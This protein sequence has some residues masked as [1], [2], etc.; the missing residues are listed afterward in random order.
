MNRNSS[1]YFIALCLAGIVAGFDASIVN[2]AFPVIKKAL[3]ANITQMQ[4]M[5]TCFS[6]LFSACTVPFGMLSDL[7][8][9]RE[10]L[11]ITLIVLTL[12]SLGAGLAQTPWFLMV[13]RGLQ[14]ACV[15]MFFPCAVGT[16]QNIFPEAI[17]VRTVSIFFALFGVGVGIGPLLGAVLMHWLS[18]RWVFFINIPFALISLFITYIWGIE[19]KREGKNTLIDWLGAL[20]FI[21]GIGAFVFILNE[22][23]YYGWHTPIIAACILTVIAFLLL[24]FVEKKAAAPLI[25]PSLYLN[26]NFAIATITTSIGVGYSFVFLFLIP[27]YL[28]MVL[29]FSIFMA[30]I[31]LCAMTVMV[32]ISPMISGALFEKNK[33]KLIV[34]IVFLGD[35]AGLVLASYFGMDGPLWLV[36]L[37][38]I[39]IGIA[40]GTI[41][42]VSTPFSIGKNYQH[43]GVITGGLITNF[44]M[45]FVIFFNFA[46][47]FFHYGIRHVNFVYGLHLAC[48]VLLIIAVLFWLAATMIMRKPLQ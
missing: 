47:M 43:A 30:G 4:W 21:V 5:L 32:I 41:N 8:G 31:T 26:R 46:M 42:S 3:N 19:S 29:K 24:F 10:M 36:I 35:V 16:I 28:H 33:K 9:R 2:S 17:R 48:Y 45:A 37:S 39:L 25:M 23:P 7:K 12:V 11:L 14:G 40:W 1:I 27:L 13:M 44:N 38:I 20:C 6:L 15:A 22:W 18:W 34:H